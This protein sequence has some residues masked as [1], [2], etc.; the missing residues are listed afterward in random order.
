MTIKNQDQISRNNS[1]APVTNFHIVTTI[2]KNLGSGSNISGR[3]WSGCQINQ[4]VPGRGLPVFILNVDHKSQLENW[5]QGI[6]GESKN[7]RIWTEEEKAISRGR[8]YAIISQQ[9][10]NKERHSPVPEQL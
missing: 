2:L 1:P 4:F 7:K 3:S 9:K 6:K 8:M 5:L 10:I